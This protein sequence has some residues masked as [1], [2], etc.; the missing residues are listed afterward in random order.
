MGEITCRVIKEKSMQK[1]TNQM[2]FTL[3]EL[4][5]AV[6][7]IGILAAVAIPAFMKNVKKAKTTEAVINVKKITDGAVSY[8]LEEK[9]GAGSAVPIAKQFPTTPEEPVAPAMG[10]CC[11]TAAKK[12]APDATAW[13]PATWQSLKF[14][15]DDPHYY[16]YFYVRGRQSPGS[17]QQ[18][19]Q[20]ADGS[21]PAEYFFAGALGDLNCDGVYSTFEMMGAI[22]R[23]GS[24]T[25]AGGMYKDME[26][27]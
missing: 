10:A 21:T 27:E 19:Q 20:L 11:L 3:V 26:L 13:S 17:G 25:T 9:V 4:M 5:I 1:S 14:S 22:T 7:I 6:A 24:V 23:D 12:C 16:S 8:Y 2:G 15:M 18:P